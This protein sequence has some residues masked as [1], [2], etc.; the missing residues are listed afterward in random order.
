MK[1]VWDLKKVLSNLEAEGEGSGIRDVST[2]ATEVAPKFSDTLTLSPPVQ[3]G[4]ILPT[5][6]EVASKFFLRLRPWASSWEWHS[7]FSWGHF[8][9]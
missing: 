9:T 7:Y 2:G 4:Q 6:A 3:W 1:K 8:T 5:I